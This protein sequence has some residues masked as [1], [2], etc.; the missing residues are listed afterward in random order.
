MSSPPFPQDYAAQEQNRESRHYCD[1]FAACA[2][3]FPHK[4]AIRIS[5]G[6]TDADSFEEWG[7]S[8]LYS[9][10]I[11]LSL[12]LRAISATGER[13]LLLVPSGAEFIIA[14]FACLHAGIIAVP[15]YPPRRNRN[16]DRV[17]GIFHDCRPGLILTTPA[18][19]QAVTETLPETGA[20]MIL[21]EPDDEEPGIISSLPPLTSEGGI[22]FLQ[23]TSGSTG[24]PRGTIITHPALMANLRAIHAL[25]RHE[26]D[27]EVV[28]WLPPFHDMGLIGSVLMPLS[29][30]MTL[31]LL[32][33]EEF[34][35]QPR[36]WLDVIAS[37][38][39]Q[40]TAGAPDFAYDLLAS[41][42]TA[43]DA[44]ELDL[45]RWRIAFNG[46][47]PIRRETLRK[48]NARFAPSGFRSAAWLPCYGLAETTLLASG[49]HGW[50]DAVSVA[51]GP[52]SCGLA[53]HETTLSIR[54]AETGQTLPDGQEGEIYVR[55]P[56]VAAGYWEN[57]SA[58]AAA[59]PEPGTLRTGDIGF[60]RDGQL[61]VTGRLKDLI[62]SR[63]RNLYPH[64]IEAAASTVIPGPGGANSIAAFEVPG[65][66]GAAPS[67]GLL[68]EAPRAWVSAH[69]RQPEALAPHCA[70]LREAIAAAFEVTPTL[71]A[72]VAPGDFPRTSSGKV[73]RHAARSLAAASQD[74]RV[75]YKDSGPA[76]APAD[77]GSLLIRQMPTPPRHTAD[78]LIQ[79]LRSFA[80]RRL[81]SQLMDERR[82]VAPHVVLEFGNNG[83]FGLQVPTA[84][85]GL[86]L[87]FAD[88]YRV[89]EQ[90]SA[91]DLSLSLMAGIHNGLGLYPL[92]HHA[93][94]ALRDALVPGMAAGR[95][96]V[97][98]ATTEASS[99][100]H[101]KSI[102][103]TATGL[104][105]GSWS[106]SGR[107][108]WIGLGSW[109]QTILVTARARS[110][111]GEFGG[112]VF[113]AVA[114]DTEG[115][116]FGEEAITMGVKGIVQVPIQFENVIVPAGRELGTVGRGFDVAYDTMRVARVGLAACSLGAM[117]RCLQWMSTYAS[118]REVAGGLLS[119]LPSSQARLANV[120]GAIA[121]VDA[122]VRRV[123][124]WM[125]ADVTLPEE[126]YLVCKATAPE[127]LGEVADA[128]MQMLG[129][130]GY[131]ENNGVAQ[132][133]RDARLLRIFEGPTEVINT[134]L[135][136]RLRR[137][138]HAL[139]DFIARQG[140]FE[141]A[142]QLRCL[143]G[144][145]PDRDD[146]A[147]GEIASLTCLH[148]LASEPGTDAAA[149]PWL[150]ERLR[151]RSAA[152]A[153]AP[154]VEIAEV[155]QRLER[156]I[157]C[158]EQTLPGEDRLPDPL[159]RVSALLPRPETLLPLIPGPEAGEPV[160][161]KLEQG[162][163]AFLKR[164]GLGDHATIPSEASFPSLGVDSLAAAS[165]AVEIEK[166]FR[167]RITDE[168]LYDYKT[169]ASLAAY[170][171]TC[172]RTAG[173]PAEQG[174]KLWEQTLQG[175]NERHRRMK[176]EGKDFY[177]IPFENQNAA[178]AMVAGNKCI[179][180]SGYSYLGLMNHPVVLAQM[181][182]AAGENG[183]S[184]HGSR[185]L[186]NGAWHAALET[187]LAKVFKAEQAIVF[188]TG[189][190][191]NWSV[192]STLIGG[193]DQIIGD[194]WIHASLVDGCEA[195][196]ARFDLFRHNDVEHLAELLEQPVKGKR[197]VVIDGVYSMEG[198]IAP[199]PEISTL[200]HEHGAWLMV[201]EAH[202]LGVL[203]PRGLGVQEHFDL[204]PDAIDIK[205][206]TLSKAIPS[207]GGYIAGSSELISALK[208]NVRPFIF[209]GAPTPPMVAAAQAG[210]EI[211]LAE[212]ERVQLLHENVRHFR[213]GLRRHGIITPE[214]RSAI[215]PLLCRDDV[216]AF[217]MAQR[218]LADGLYVTP[219][220]YPAVPQNAPRLRCSITAALSHADL[221]LAVEV[222]VRHR[223]G[224][225]TF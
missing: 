61:Y 198:D 223:E 28:T 105:N 170:I 141:A 201:D 24:T 193:E 82:T 209:S 62:I 81:N 225:R 210:L 92:L 44:A 132:M 63:G 211:L 185:L 175:M 173:S 171:E 8:L 213:E 164:E 189:F 30:G 99:G 2:R 183:V 212:P 110:A 208:H 218:C 187:S 47:E 103:T 131:V 127:F 86:G 76:A 38:P 33:P 219:I 67:L 116:T 9:Q 172:T 129:A 19:S 21:V 214:N 140:G 50:Q 80:R 180:L 6:Q 155:E 51:D 78:T 65:T 125:D 192:I 167:L 73:Q 72:F 217:T 156:E 37:R 88:T 69:R 143:A 34:L 75:F 90:L 94:P 203:G 224:L 215:V 53:A 7:Y 114:A 207:A 124:G 178:S 42:L 91:I 134:A 113:L 22:A 41:R 137:G 190:S 123:A 119:S 220:V 165:L 194:E 5:R 179:V 48:F 111:K 197:L 26:P 186:A 184:S 17:L 126:I 199:V 159:T 25:S 20:S 79:W 85:G 146:T 10:V 32:T 142:D 1:S 70:T 52:V 222:L 101:A 181:L 56:S 83:L 108:Q 11:A 49:I 96:L 150:G 68:I 122:L 158:T 148:W 188:T 202:S 177:G 160:L 3:S 104:A 121:A 169:L 216:A 166:T 163:I 200:A 87:G 97:S 196:G 57:P 15:A 149:A 40:V 145:H 102:Q 4:P 58:T 39:A 27:H 55:S 130:R 60:M 59:F 35:R 31:S 133:F 36:R 12:R 43:E 71:I 152:R 95:N 151:L 157:G 162:L 168:T 16:R 77:P 64:D 46:A 153:S 174:K 128:A 23:Y 191:T 117:K 45:S 120:L 221:D 195:S 206:G 93:P 100:S 135:G 115:L 107:K 13:A 154:A 112:S 84:L 138:Q 54:H 89:I 176:A 136:Q 205:M 144:A 106:L 118:R 74:E 18:F 14:F 139:A 98:F 109:A 182:R 147:L 161:K 66:N 29:L 204:P